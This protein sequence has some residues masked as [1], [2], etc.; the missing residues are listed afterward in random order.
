MPELKIAI[1]DL[2]ERED[3]KSDERIL[4]LRRFCIEQNW[5]V[6]HEYRDIGAGEKSNSDFESMLRDAKRAKFDLILFWSLEHFSRDGAVKILENFK[7]LDRLGV[8]FRS[9]TES[10]LDSTGALK[11]S[12]FSF[13][14]TMARQERQRLSE[15]VKAGMEK[16]RAEG[17]LI[18]RPR[19]SSEKQQQIQSLA[20]TGRY[21]M[22]QIAKRVGVSHRTVGR[23]LSS[24]E[25]SQG[26]GRESR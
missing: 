21:S 24:G 15:K 11:D 14:E 23:Y 8:Y 6:V 7:E 16:A 2:G 19:I 9:F 12:I 4:E 17:R 13:L 10:Y 5:L 22:R 26:E 18:S 25:S 1:Y 3:L 20:D